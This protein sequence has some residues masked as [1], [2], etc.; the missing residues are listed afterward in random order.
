MADRML[1]S[2]APVLFGALAI[3]AAAPPV[4]AN[5]PQGAMIGGRVYGNVIPERSFPIPFTEICIV[6]GRVAFDVHE[7]DESTTGGRCRPGDAGWVISRGEQG[8][9]SF[10]EARS[11]CAELG[12][13]LPN[14]L[15]WQLSCRNAE[16]FELDG[17]VGDSEWAANSPSL[18]LA[19]A[20][21]G[22]VHVAEHGST[23]MGEAWC[24]GRLWNFRATFAD[25][26]LDT[27]ERAFRCAQ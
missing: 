19:A 27:G 8:A 14:P 20:A 22:G 2:P 13:R 23:M 15:E 17:I 12:M 1:L 21:P 18:L 9:R 6:A 26:R 24:D 25:E 16:H 11:E 4:L 5:A 10:H 3:L 7:P